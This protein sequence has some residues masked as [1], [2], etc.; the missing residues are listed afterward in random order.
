MEQHITALYQ[1]KTSAER[2][3]EGLTM[4]PQ[5]VD[6]SAVVLM[7]GR[8]KEKIQRRLTRARLH[9]ERVQAYFI[10]NRSLALEDRAV[11]RGQ[12]AD[13]IILV[14]TQMYPWLAPRSD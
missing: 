12:C 5:R 14:Y 2:V 7:F 10:K 8:G 9:A 13:N 11:K 1:C 3:G 4:S 6:V